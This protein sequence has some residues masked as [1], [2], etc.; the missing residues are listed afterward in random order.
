MSALLSSYR[1]S[2]EQRRMCCWFTSSTSCSPPLWIENLLPS[3][4]S[5][6]SSETTQGMENS[7]PNPERI[8]GG[9][10]EGWRLKWSSLHSSFPPPFHSPPSILLRLPSLLSFLPSPVSWSL[11]RWPCHCSHS[12]HCQRSHMVA[13]PCFSWDWSPHWVGTVIK[14]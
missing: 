6:F 3:P 2:A 4:H 14:E 12:C 1:G 8:E 13:S 9:E 7:C 10:T 11:E 5:T